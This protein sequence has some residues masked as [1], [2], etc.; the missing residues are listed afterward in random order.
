[1]S[2]HAANAFGW[3]LSA[4][5]RSAGISCTTPPEIFFCDTDE[6]S[7]FRTAAV[8]WPYTFDS[9]NRSPDESISLAVVDWQA[10]PKDVTD[11]SG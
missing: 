8:A 4:F 5:F 11:V 7:G 1:M 3:D 6:L 10:K 2:C 9:D